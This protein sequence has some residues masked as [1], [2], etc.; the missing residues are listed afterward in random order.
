[1]YFIKIT[2][3]AEVFFCLY[4]TRIA[5]NHITAF[6]F[7]MNQTG[8]LAVKNEFMFQNT[9]CYT[10]INA[11]FKL[12][13]KNN[14]I[15]YG[16]HNIYKWMHERVFFVTAVKAARDFSSAQFAKISNTLAETRRVASLINASETVASTAGTWNVCRREWNGKVRYYNAIVC[17]KYT[18]I[19]VHIQLCIPPLINFNFSSTIWPMHGVGLVRTLAFKYTDRE[20][21]RPVDL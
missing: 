18:C 20:R 12:K 19:V 17:L 14:L 16:V 21:N 5:L 3:T 15:L 1:M 13:K 8:H 9:A 7:W 2:P 10:V 11:T 4:A 6:I